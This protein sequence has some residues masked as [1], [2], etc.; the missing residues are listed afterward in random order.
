MA[1]CLTSSSSL[2]RRHL[3]RGTLLAHGAEIP[4]FFQHEDFITPSPLDFLP[5]PFS[6][7]NRQFI[8]LIYYVVY[9]LLPP[10]ESKFLW[11]QE[12]GSPFFSGLTL[13]P[14]SRYIVRTPGIFVERLPDYVIL[15]MFP[16]AGVGAHPDNPSFLTPGKLSWFLV[17]ATTGSAWVWRVCQKLWPCCPPAR[18]SEPCLLPAASLLQLPP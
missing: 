18:S 14:G 13:G 15:I 2:C 6:F 4:A 11:G 3:L 10:L 7:S 8:L 12:F 5:F 16:G 9:S 1:C 17:T